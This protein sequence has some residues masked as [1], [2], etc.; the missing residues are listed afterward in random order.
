MT[1]K[2]IRRCL[3]NTAILHTNGATTWS[4][5]LNSVVRDTK[6]PA[7]TRYEISDVDG[8]VLFQK[9]TYATHTTEGALSRFKKR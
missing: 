9:K 5:C 3:Q 7:G 8:F 2:Q 6:E 1:R 4:F